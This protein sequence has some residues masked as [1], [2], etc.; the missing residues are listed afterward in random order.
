M[1][2]CVT[3]KKGSIAGTLAVSARNVHTQ[4]LG[5]LGKR[6]SVNDRQKVSKELDSGACETTHPIGLGGYDLLNN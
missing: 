4:E 2:G 1:P 5:I 3:D 6:Q